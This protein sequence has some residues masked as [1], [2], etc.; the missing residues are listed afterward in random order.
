MG[1]VCMIF[2]RKFTCLLRNCR[3]N[4]WNF[5]KFLKQCTSVKMFSNVNS[6]IVRE[7]S[8][9]AICPNV[10]TGQK[11]NSK[12]FVVFVWIHNWGQILSDELFVRCT[13]R[14]LSATVIL[15]KKFTWIRAPSFLFPLVLP[16][17]TTEFWLGSS[18]SWTHCFLQLVP[19]T[20]SMRA[21]FCSVLHRNQRLQWDQYQDWPALPVQIQCSRKFTNSPSTPPLVSHYHSAMK[22]PGVSVATLLLI[23]CTKPLTD[24][25]SFVYSVCKT[26]QS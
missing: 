22:D 8:V 17:Q 4:I 5:S 24:H 26:D 7:L 12:R 20:A 1:I 2:W 11:G 25:L 19:C 21:S 14:A 15:L 23:V 16:S 18:S 6:L 3:G 9:G 10:R 13:V